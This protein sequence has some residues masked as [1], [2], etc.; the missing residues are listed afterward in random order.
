MG[1]G[2][3]F[4]LGLMTYLYSFFAAPGAAADELVVNPV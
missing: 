2:V 4:L 1:G 3:M